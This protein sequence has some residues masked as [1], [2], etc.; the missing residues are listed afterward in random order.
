MRRIDRPHV[1]S[2]NVSVPAVDHS[3]TS[4]AAL[5]S[6][7]SSEAVDEVQI[8]PAAIRA[9]H[10]DDLI[11]FLQQWSEDLDQR[12]A[13]LHADIATHERRE[14][15]FR[16]WMQNRRAELESQIDDYRQAQFKAEAAARRFVLTD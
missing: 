7:V 3:C 13:R 8:D 1:V 12:A 4:D 5:E 11:T 15:A 6:S 9:A 16:M 2:E 14:R 10:A